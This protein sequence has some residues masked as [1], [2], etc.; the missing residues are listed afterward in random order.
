LPLAELAA[1]FLHMSINRI[2]RSAH[3]AQ[4]LVLYDFL[5]R[6][7]QSASARSQSPALRAVISAPSGVPAA[8]AC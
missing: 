8:V 6:L 1:S 4:E 2:L 7:Y 5:A 3:R